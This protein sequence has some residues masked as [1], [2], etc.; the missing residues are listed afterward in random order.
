MIFISGFGF[1]PFPTNV[2]AR[3]GTWRLAAVKGG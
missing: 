2:E 1:F 3:A